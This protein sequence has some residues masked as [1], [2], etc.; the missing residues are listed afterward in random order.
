MLKDYP[1]ILV[2]PAAA[3]NIDAALLDNLAK[4]AGFIRRKTSRFSATGFFLSLLKAVGS[5]Q[6]SLN[7]LCISLAQH[8]PRALCKQGL[9]Y[10]FSEPALDFLKR[11]LDKVNEASS[12]VPGIESRFG[13]ILL[14]D[15]TQLRL[16]PGN[17]AHF[18]GMGND[19]GATA[20]AKLDVISNLLTG[21]YFPSQISDGR[22]QDRSNGPRIFD[23]LESGD[24]VLRDM[25]YFDVD[26]FARMEDL[27]ASWISRLHALVHVWDMEGVCLEERLSS[28]QGQVLDMDVTLTH[29]G[30]RARLIAIR[31][32][33]EV[34]A[35]RRAKGKERRKRMGNTA[36]KRSLEREG[37][38]LYVTN[39]SREEFAAKDIVTLYEGRWAI[40]IRFRALKGSTRLREMFQRR[41]NKTTLNV[42]LTAVMIFAHMGAKA[43]LWLRS[44]APVGRLPSAEKVYQWL[45]NSLLSLA[46]IRAPIPY[47]MRALCLDRRART[48][49]QRKIEP[50]F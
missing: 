37:W 2:Q 11:L 34:K 41:T 20:A 9:A 23:Y 47:D 48:C 49:L 13:R 50:L 46:N 36:T 18:K 28:S 32:T 38:N 10:H 6:S 21:E 25:G 14:Q 42:L 22:H 15:S 27:G 12:N 8:Q 45:A 3:L 7:Q 5:G 16:H 4:E 31:A 43:I 29:K 17:A 44:K 1:A 19:A 35:R 39:L 26:S 30:H 24:L 40:E 33:E